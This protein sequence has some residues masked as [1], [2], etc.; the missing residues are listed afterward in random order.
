MTKPTGTESAPDPKAPPP[1][2]EGVA[3]YFAQRAAEEGAGRSAMSLENVLDPRSDSP[4]AE[5]PDETGKPSAPAAD[6]DD[7]GKAGKDGGEQ[8]TEP[9]QTKADE[10]GDGT[11]AD[12]PGSGEPEGEEPA[13]LKKRLRNAKRAARQTAEAK[14]TETQAENARLREQ[15]A[16]AN[17]AA[18]KE[19]DAPDGK[20]GGDPPADAAPEDV[21]FPHRE[22]YGEDEELY[23]ADVDR[24]YADEAL[25]GPKGGTKP[26]SDAKPEDEP[27]ADT[28]Q[29]RETEPDAEPSPE[30][31]VAELAE[32]LREI[33]DTESG[34]EEDL[35]GDFSDLVAKGRARL[36]E[37]MLEH[38]VDHDQAA[39]IVRRFI[40]KP[41]LCKRI[42]LKPKSKQAEAMDKLLGT[43]EGGGERSE[44]T[45]PV[46]DDLPS[47]TKGVPQDPSKMDIAAYSSW[48]S[49]N[50]GMA[51]MMDALG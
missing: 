39:D 1:S 41:Y 19:T 10:G 40:E 15:L 7:S 20:E 18:S 38:L 26:A 2:T 24:W 28:R 35:D 49:Q 8:A 5:K 23:L 45:G 36:T 48:R 37:T 42:A 22:D 14:L 17:Q 12:Q 29:T 16:Q 9:T 33:L 4:S 3:D 25:E 6:A 50:N 30:Q 21:P 32:T 11:A 44:P 34:D 13:W 47:Q 27:K 51:G 43:D 31:R 46:V